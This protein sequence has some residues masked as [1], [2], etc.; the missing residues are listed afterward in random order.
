MSEQKPWEC[1][2]GNR[3]ALPYFG[4][5]RNGDAF[6]ICKACFEKIM[7]FQDNARK[8]AEVAFKRYRRN[9][10]IKE[11]LYCLVFF[12]IPCWAIGYKFGLTY[13]LVALGGSVYTPTFLL[14]KEILIR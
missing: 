3:T 8:E 1:A 2:C 6:Y 5:G 14:L 4:V 13:E 9:R 7:V 12:I 10:I 11:I